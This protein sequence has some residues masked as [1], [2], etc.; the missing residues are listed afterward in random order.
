V[1]DSDG[2]AGGASKPGKNGSGDGGGGG[3]SRT[4][5]HLLGGT[6]LLYALLFVVD[7][8]NASAALESAWSL[9]LTIAP[10]L[11]LVTA[12]VALVNYA[13]TVDAIARYLGSES[14]ATGY[15]VAIVGGVL[16]H[17]PVYAWYTLLADL[18]E[19]G[20]RDGLIAVFLYN[21]AIKL[22]LLP[23]FLYYFDVE[24]AAVLLGTMVVA[25]VVQGVVVEWV[26]A[27][28]THAAA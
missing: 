28:W 25:S 19:R 20:M 13:V 11:L 4:D 6:I 15:L 26:L 8:A 5:W 24:Y 21:R 7:P 9:A 23:L 12:F 14:G 2:S 17:G 27:W 10:I 1:S 16:S 18:R 22:P 3:Q